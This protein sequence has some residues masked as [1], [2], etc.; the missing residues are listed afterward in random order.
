MHTLTR[1]TTILGLLTAAAAPLRAA[2]YTPL[3]L[4]VPN[5]R[6]LQFFSV[7]VA[8]GAKLFEAEGLAP[9]ILPAPQPR[10]VGGRLF[11]GEADVAVLPPPM[12]LGMMAEGK[13][14]RLFAN[15]FANE[16]I[17]LVLQT[18]VAARLKI[19][20]AA[21]LR[22]KLQALKGLKVGVAGEPPPR[23]HAMFAAA[24]M[25]AATDVG[26]VIV[27]GSGQVAAFKSGAIDALFAHTPY[28]ETVMVEQGAVL[29]VDTS[30]GEVPGL[31]GGQIHSLGA[32]EATVR[33]RRELLVK[34]TRAIA[35]AQRLAHTDLPATVNALIASG[36]VGTASHPQIEAIAAIYA[37]AVPRTPRISIPGI[38]RS[39]ELYPAHP[40]HPDFSKV[41]P[42]AFVTQDI[43]EAALK[44]L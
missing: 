17:N 23:L 10:S 24:G 13:P 29:I 32:M 2:E 7:W 39:A 25:N 30:G 44:T 12:Y 9:Q 35:A 31:A 43:A 28:L 16:P 3:R 21:P 14:V 22:D 19:P 38:R 40:R 6:N 37:D 42:E 20:E 15:L 8:L 36:A 27:P 26:I 33:E 1:R 11:T 5:V 4:E 18:A 41:G 34:T